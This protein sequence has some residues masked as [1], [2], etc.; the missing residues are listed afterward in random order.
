MYKCR[1]SSSNT[2]CSV[3]SAFIM[4]SSIVWD[5]FKSFTT[6]NGLGQIVGS[7]EKRWKGFWVILTSVFLVATIYSAVSTVVEFFKY[8]VVTSYSVIHKDY[9]NLPSVTIC[10]I[11]RVHCGNLMK[12]L[13]EYDENNEVGNVT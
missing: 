13:D 1:T 6:I 7:T 11:N 4:S 5:W 3:L 8:D 10:N 2:T 9:L 12:K